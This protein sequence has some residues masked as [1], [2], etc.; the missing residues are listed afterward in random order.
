MRLCGESETRFG[1][2]VQNYIRLLR[3]GNMP[4]N[5]WQDTKKRCHNVLSSK[6]DPLQK[7]TASQP[8]FLGPQRADSFIRQGGRGVP[9]VEHPSEVVVGP[10]VGHGLGVQGPVD[11]RLSSLHG[12][13]VQ[14]HR[15][16][17]TTC[18]CACVGGCHKVQPL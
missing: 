8:G 6:S 4:V 2:R 1:P 9:L 18:V 15:G 5:Q 17:Y 10:V 3:I 13:A 16:G 14:L 12:Q 11:S 7:R